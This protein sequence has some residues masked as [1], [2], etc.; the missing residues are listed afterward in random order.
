MCHCVTVNY[1]HISKAET[2]VV[3]ASMM[4][5]MTRAVHFGNFIDVIKGGRSKLI[6]SLV[7]FNVVV[8]DITSYLNIII[9][10]RIFFL[11]LACEKIKSA[12]STVVGSASRA[13]GYPL[14]VHMS[15]E[16]LRCFQ[17]IKF[18]WQKLCT[19]GEL[20]ISKRALKSSKI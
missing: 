2:E 20:K 13:L 8:V 7:L 18:L 17:S 14:S 4:Q 5:Y 6:L 10:G 15:C 9:V 1:H 16:I 12:A 3:D 19:V 11:P